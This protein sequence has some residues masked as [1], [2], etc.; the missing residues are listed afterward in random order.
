MKIC[1]D[2]P[3]LNDYRDVRMYLYAFAIEFALM[4][5]LVFM[6]MTS[7]FDQPPV[8]GGG[9]QG[10]GER[11][12]ELAIAKTWRQRG[13]ANQTAMIACGYCRVKL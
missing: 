2:P 7:Q 9:G 1:D 10:G 4:G 8:V 3:S 6:V 5:A 12:V 13:A 11:G